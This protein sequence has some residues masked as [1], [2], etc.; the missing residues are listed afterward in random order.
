MIA[1]DELIRC[2]GRVTVSSKPG[3]EEWIRLDRAT[4]AVVESGPKACL[5]GIRAAHLVVDPNTRGTVIGDLIDGGRLWQDSRRNFT[6]VDLYSEAL[7]ILRESH[8]R[9][10]W[11]SLIMLTNKFLMGVDQREVKRSLWRI[12]KKADPEV[13]RMVDDVLS[14]NHLHISIF[15]RF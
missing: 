2:A 8:H 13:K 6:D 7:S 10:H 1:V 4:F 5:E 15:D 3:G 11:V 12:R 9:E 14:R